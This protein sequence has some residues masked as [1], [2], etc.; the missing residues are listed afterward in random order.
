[1]DPLT[2]ALAIAGVR[3]TLGAKIEAGRNWGWWWSSRSGELGAAFHA[4]TS[5]TVWVAVPG[6]DAVEL[7]P[8]DVILL[9][10][11]TPHAIGSDLQAVQRTNADRFDTGEAVGDGVHRMGT[12][13][14]RSQLLCAHYTQD[15][16]VHTQVLSL[17]PDVVHVRAGAAH[18][19]GA[20]VGL[21]ADELVRPGLA[22]DVVLNR[23]VDVL[24]VRVLRS[25]VEQAPTGDLTGS[26][27]LT[28][29]RDPI[30]HA[31]LTELHAEPGRAWTADTLAQ[32]VAVSRATLTRRFASAAGE[33]PGAY[34]LRWRM[35][36]AA[37]RLRDTD[38]AIGTIGR[39]LGYTSEPAFNRAFSRARDVPPGR[40][41]TLSRAA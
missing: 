1:M 15:A 29:L 33:T 4:V 31:A 9:P 13:D 7:M 11:G 5:G 32:A 26:S 16:A 28:G 24:L 10:R 39:D 6:G 17:L 20:L 38:D 35:D 23:L 18:G 14:T 40:Y 34:L 22:S 30:V 8:G 3:S 19:L 12:G 2:D 36:L 21:I 41:R 37:R 27:W 25:W